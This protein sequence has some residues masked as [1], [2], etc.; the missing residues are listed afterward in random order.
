M[1]HAI[2]SGNVPLLGG[3]ELR[4]RDSEIVVCTSIRDVGSLG[5]A[6]AY[7]DRRQVVVG[8]FVAGVLEDVT[9]YLQGESVTR[10]GTVYGL[11]QTIWAEW[12]SSMDTCVQDP[13]GYQNAG[14]ANREFPSHQVLGEHCLCV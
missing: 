8:R 2:A 14:A 3:Q 11:L 9:G 10:L 4:P 13:V 12:L 5:R 1:R 6:S 7:D